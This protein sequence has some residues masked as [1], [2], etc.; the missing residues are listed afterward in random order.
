M[1]VYRSIPYEHSCPPGGCAMCHDN[2]YPPPSDPGHYPFC[3]QYR[4][5]NQ[6]VIVVI[7]DVP[8]PLL[9]PSRR[10]GAPKTMVYVPEL[11]EVTLEPMQ[12][13]SK[14]LPAQKKPA[15]APKRAARR[16]KGL[17]GPR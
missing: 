14:R 17:R 7:A 5:G 1:V 13:T 9:A 12:S 4:E 16:T 2:Y 8:A 15:A 11:R 6:L 10:P 3:C